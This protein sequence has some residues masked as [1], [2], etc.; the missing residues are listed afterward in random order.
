MD[1]RQQVLGTRTTVD[2]WVLRARTAEEPQ[3]GAELQADDRIWPARRVSETARLALVGAS[4]HLQLACQVVDGPRGYATALHTVLRGALLGA[5]TAVWVLGPPEADERQQRGLRLAAKW[6]GRKAQYDEACRPHCPPED[7][8]VLND[9]VQHSKA[10]A[11]MVKALWTATPTMTEAQSPSDTQ[12]ME[13]VADYMFGND[14]ARAASI[15]RYWSELSGDAH[16]LGW[17]LVSRRTSP[18]MREPGG[19]RLASTEADISHIADPYLASFTVLKR[20]WSLF[21][22]RCSGS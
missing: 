21:D 1:L 18:L 11:A 8:S 4:E 20:G 16:A 9:Q 5:V 3:P 12:V 2:G 22:Q 15:M 17:Q 7:L 10:Q 13:W 19:F 6:Y 14:E